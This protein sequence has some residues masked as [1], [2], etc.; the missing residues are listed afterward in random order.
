MK[1]KWMKCKDGDWYSLLSI[2][3]DH[4]HFNDLNGVYIIW[5]GDQVVTL[6]SGIIK[7]RLKEHRENPEITKFKNLKVTCA[8]VH[9]NHMKG[10]EKY[11]LDSLNPLF[12][13]YFN[14]C[15]PIPV[16]FPW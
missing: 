4:N 14:T 11:L 12:C 3:L 9:E 15:L 13:E 8:C 6:G 2:D 1:L 10:V 16:I 7:N 5:S